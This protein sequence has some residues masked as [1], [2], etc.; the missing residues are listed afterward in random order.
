M[1]I[2][3]NSAVCFGDWSTK[4]LV[5]GHECVTKRKTYHTKM[6]HRMDHTDEERTSLSVSLYLSIYLSVCLSIIGEI[7]KK[8]DRYSYSIQ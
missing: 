4:L 3:Q 5:N 2:F 6:D 7:E 1:I 8:E